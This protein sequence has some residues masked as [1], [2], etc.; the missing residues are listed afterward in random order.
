M[1]VAGG[2][3]G[4]ANWAWAIGPDVLKS[5]YQTGQLIIPPMMM[6]I[7]HRF[8]HFQPLMASTVV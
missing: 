1:L 4:M 3:A 6:N 7:N 5:R 8:L 2:L